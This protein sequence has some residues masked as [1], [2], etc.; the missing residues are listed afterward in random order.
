MHNV[1]IERICPGDAKCLLG[2][3]DK[4]QVDR[5]VV[6]GLDLIDRD[7]QLVYEPHYLVKGLAV[8]AGFLPLADIILERS[9]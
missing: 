2:Y 9:E 8:S 7:S 4:R 3:V 5:V 6:L 1:F